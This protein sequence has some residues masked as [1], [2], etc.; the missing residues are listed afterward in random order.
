MLDHIVGFRV[1]VTLCPWTARYRSGATRPH[2]Q[3]R[4]RPRSSPDDQPCQHPSIDLAGGSPGGLARRR[5]LDRDAGWPAALEGAARAPR[6]DHERRRT[7]SSPGSPTACALRST[8]TPVPSRSRSPPPEAYGD[9]PVPGTSWW[10]VSR[11]RPGRLA[12]SVSVR[13][14]GCR[15]GPRGWSCGCRDAAPTVLHEVAPV[16]AT[17]CVASSCARH[18]AGRSTA[19]RSPSAIRRRAPPAPG[20]RLVAAQNSYDLTALGMSGQC[21]L[22]PPLAETI[23]AS[24]PDLV[25]LCLG[26]NIYGAA[27]FTERSLPPAVIGFVDHARRLTGAPIVIMSPTTAGPHREEER[28][29]AGLDQREIRALIHRAV[30]MLQRH[31][32]LITLIDGSEN[33]H[34]P[35]D[36]PA[37]R[38]APSHRGGLSRDGRTARPASRL[39]ARLERATGREAERAEDPGAVRISGRRVAGRDDLVRVTRR[40]KR[41]TPGRRCRA[42]PAR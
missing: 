1:G 8:P 4:R 23:G 16:G 31:D 24:R 28:N 6:A 39:R 40:R 27:T 7:T 12:G 30:A 42:T 35:G 32:P 19:A 17:E 26:A 13:V 10:T 9:S 38:P 22:D 21:Q 41:S 3:H 25:T 20:P 14:E 18:R 36:A 2:P 34:R 37:R 11:R 33:R 29:S 15:V 5:H